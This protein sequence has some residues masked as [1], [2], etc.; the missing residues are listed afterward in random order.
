MLSKKIKVISIGDIHLGH[1]K[2]PARNT[3]KFLE[4]VFP[5]RAKMED[6]DLIFITGDVFDRLLSYPDDNVFEIELW[7]NKFLR[8][9]KKYDVV[10]RMVEGTPSHDWKQSKS[11]MKINEMM[12][13]GA[14][15][16][17]FEA[18]DIEHN[19]KFGIDILYIPD[20]WRP[21]CD[22]TWL[23]VQKLMARKGLDKVDFI[24]MHG[25]FSYQLPEFLSSST[26]DPERYL[27]I[28]RYF[29]YVGH[30]HK[31]TV[32]DRIIAAGS[33]DRLA[34]N[35]E[36]DKGYVE[37]IVDPKGQHKITF[38]P[39]EMAIVYK[40]LACVDDNVEKTLKFLE[41]EIK[42]LPEHSYIRI[43][44][45]A[46]NPILSSSSMETLKGLFPNVHLDTLLDKDT[47]VNSQTLVDLRNSYQPIKITKNNIVELLTSRLSSKVDCNIK[48]DKAS[49]LLK[50]FI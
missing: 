7:I 22:D 4:E 43:K 36:E 29:I 24:N 44:A 46:D 5:N 8:I 23:D 25:A 47:K 6:V 17:Y 32:N 42:K 10:V 48:L 14:D 19:E 3:L 30:I 11:F 28:T 16:K 12:D 37:T 34:H 40:T 39:N 20:E 38:I 18:L 41:K 45:S 33:T 13:I 1:R 26:H 27:S 50:Q 15:I 31:H 2:T 49:D 9:C 35:E 21:E